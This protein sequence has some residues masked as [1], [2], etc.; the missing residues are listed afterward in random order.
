MFRYF[1]AVL[2]ALI[3][4]ATARGT[5]AELMISSQLFQKLICPT[6][7]HKIFVVAEKL[8]VVIMFRYFLVVLAALITVATARETDVSHGKGYGA[9]GY[10]SPF[11]GYGYGAVKNYGG[12][13][14]GQPKVPYGYAL[15]S[16]GGY[17]NGYI[18]GY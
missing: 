9:W 11:G 6:E 8:V 14:Y 18:N 2:A 17:G 4:V 7:R 1:L 16:Y 13:G 5:N 10:G 3:T 12:Y 15:P